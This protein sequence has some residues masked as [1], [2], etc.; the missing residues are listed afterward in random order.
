MDHT[1]VGTLE[2]MCPCRMPEQMG[3]I[4][5]HDFRDQKG[6]AGEERMGGLATQAFA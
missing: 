6:G 2:A 3:T 5:L 1:G 4:S